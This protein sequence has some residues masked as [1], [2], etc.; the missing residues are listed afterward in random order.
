MGYDVIAITMEVTDET[1]TNESG[2]KGKQNKKNNSSEPRVPSPIDISLFQKYTKIKILNRINIT[3]DQP[4]SLHKISQ[5]KQVKLYDIISYLPGN[6]AVLKALTGVYDFDILSYN[7]AIDNPPLYFNR[8]LYNQFVQNGVYMELPY[9]PAIVDSTCRKNCIY[10]ASVYHAVGKSE[11][12]IVTSAGS[13]PHHFRSPY[14]V[15]SLYPFIVTFLKY[16]F[17]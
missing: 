9:S 6:A 11:N 8:K 16:F 3:V 17:G 10:T 15:I 12:I 13:D 5:S 4:A 1:F 2:K 7:P 14:D